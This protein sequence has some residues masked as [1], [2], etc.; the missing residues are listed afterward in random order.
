MVQVIIYKVTNNINGKVYIGQTKRTLQCRW[1]QHCYAV[2]SKHRFLFLKLQK[3]IKEFGVDNF[4]IEQI[5]SAESKAEADEKE[6][7]W[8]K[9]YNAI[10][11]GYNSSPGGKAGGHRKKVKAVESGL[12]FDTIVDAAKHYGVSCKAIAPVVDKPHLKSA[13]QHWISV[14]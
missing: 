7:F 12:V 6:V 4:S 3:A 13:G 2:H 8:I 1:K 14:K 5:D 9:F 11:D 10:E